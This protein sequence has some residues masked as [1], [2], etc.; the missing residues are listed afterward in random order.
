MK[1][2]LSPS[3]KQALRSL[4]RTTRDGRVRDR[5]KSV[6]HASNGWSPEDIADA[7][8]IHENTVR[9]H[10]KEY[11]EEQK[12]KPEN[13]G[14]NSFLTEEQTRELVEHLTHTTYAHTYLICTHIQ[15]TYGVDYSVAGLNKWLHK[16][17]FSYNL[18]FGVQMQ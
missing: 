18:S 16:N 13:G 3:Q 8:L 11:A 5:I 1:L 14:S 6:I 7:L 12:L 4:H 10:L 9:Q 17:G 2:F 15:Q